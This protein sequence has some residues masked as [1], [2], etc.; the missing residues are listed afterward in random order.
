MVRLGPAEAALSL[1]PNLD[2]E[3]LGFKPGCQ[4]VCGVGVG[5]LG[6]ALGIFQAII[7]TLGAWVLLQKKVVMSDVSLVAGKA[8]PLRAGGGNGGGWLDPLYT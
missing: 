6:Q 1:F 8:F 2:L 7:G 3:E 4:M 5:L